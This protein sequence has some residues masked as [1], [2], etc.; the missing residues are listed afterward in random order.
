VD[1]LECP[2]FK[3]IMEK[4]EV[5]VLEGNSTYI[6][7]GEYSGGDSAKCKLRLYAEGN[8]LATLDYS[9]SDDE[10]ASCEIELQVDGK[11]I[12]F[13]LAIYCSYDLTIALI[14]GS[15]LFTRLQKILK[16]LNIETSTSVTDFAKFLSLLAPNCAIRASGDEESS[17]S[18]KKICF[19]KK[20][21]IDIFDQASYAEQE[22]KLLSKFPVGT[23]ISAYDVLHSIGRDFRSTIL[24]VAKERGLLAKVNEFQYKVV[25]TTPMPPKTEGKNDVKYVI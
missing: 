15:A 24:E 3:P 13:E 21:K 20:D 12:K 17:Y 7:A 8:L 6:S 19:P 5:Q 25:K 9:Y 4:I 10:D 23:L 1:A 11:P 16:T 2:E 14:E 18:E 22:T